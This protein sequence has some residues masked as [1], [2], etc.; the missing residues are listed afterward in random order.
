MK[1]SEIL[2]P[3]NHGGMCIITPYAF[4]T[5]ISVAHEYSLAPVNIFF[6]DFGYI[7]LLIILFAPK[8]SLIVISPVRM[9]RFWMMILKA[10]FKKNYLILILRGTSSSIACIF[11][12]RICIFMGNAFLCIC[13][14]VNIF[15]NK[16]NFM[17][18]APMKL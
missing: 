16:L 10:H 13:I 7:L 17:S 2:Y 12:I 8:I 6:I 1:W 15:P 5:F 11:T 18:A 4:F 3:P 14:F 9:D